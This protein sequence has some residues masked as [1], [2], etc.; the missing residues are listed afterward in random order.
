VKAKAASYLYILIWMVALQLGGGA[1]A[2]ADLSAQS[3]GPAIPA[4][5]YATGL[6]TSNMAQS[7]WG[8]GTIPTIDH[9]NLI[10]GF[11]HWNDVCKASY[12]NLEERERNMTV[13]QIP[14]PLRVLRNAAA[15]F[16]ISSKLVD[17]TLA[18]FLA[19]QRFI[20]NQ[21]YITI[22]DL[23]KPAT[24]KRF[25]II[26]AWAGTA[27]AYRAAHGS[28]SDPGHTG[29][30]KKFGND[31]R[32]TTDKTSL[33]CSVTGMVYLARPTPQEPKGRLAL[34]MLG[35]SPTNDNT[36]SRG[37]YMHGAPYVDYQK[38]V[39]GSQ[40]GYVN[41]PGR[42]H[43]CPAFTYENRNEVFNQVRGGGLVCSW[44]G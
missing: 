14:K 15:Q 33:G 37:I 26:D 39:R 7:L 5:G 41:N 20:P 34:S 31:P 24:E 2:N 35:F 19:N 9:L 28:G 10:Y 38:G 8:A 29:V 12:N 13:R 23:S 25:V 1:T 18:V 17:R 21:R 30:A 27:K 44:D 22:F 16:G 40:K 4:A 6:L 36:C 32:G 42:S 3:S 43:G 11:W